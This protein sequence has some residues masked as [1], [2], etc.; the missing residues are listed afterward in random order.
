MLVRVVLLL[1]SY[2]QFFKLRIIKNKNLEEFDGILVSNKFDDVTKKVISFYNNNPFPN[3]DNEDNKSTILA[4]GDK[5]YLKSLKKLLGF[6][7]KILEVGCGT[8][9][10]SNYF[11]IG[12][13]NHVFA[14]DP[15]YNSLKLAKDFSD[16]NNIKNIKYINGSIFEDLFE[17]E[18]FDLVFCS[19]VLHHTKDTYLGFEKCAE[20]VK[21]NGYILIGLYNSYSRFPLKKILYKLFGIKVVSYFDPILK[22]KKASQASINAWL[23]DQYNHPVERSHSIQELLSWFKKFNI[24][25]LSGIPNI[26][27]V[28]LNKIYEQ[29]DKKNLH[30]RKSKL[31]LIFSQIKMNFNLL[32]KDAAL[33]CILGKKL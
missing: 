24:E 3:Y 9:Q 25:P 16:K 5:S 4:K 2:T 32:G 15:T 22:N 21:K 14:L 23:E 11:A 13:N 10:Y 6:N 33:F 17:K 18:S 31:S 1:H 30:K 27:S 20:L 8:G 19:G 26:N 7:K 28:Q 12:T 29:I